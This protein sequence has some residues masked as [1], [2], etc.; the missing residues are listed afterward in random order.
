MD[1]SF[2]T[3]VLLGGTDVSGSAASGVA[4]EMNSTARII[5]ATVKNNH[6]SGILLSRSSKLFLS[7]RKTDATGNVTGFGLNCTD[8]ESSAWDMGL[9]IGGISSACT[10]Y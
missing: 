5:G 8:P 7:E 3:Y 2:A 6:Q 1:L 4:L 10:G 9:L